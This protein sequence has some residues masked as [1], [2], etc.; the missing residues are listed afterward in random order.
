MLS[1]RSLTDKMT[2]LTKRLRRFL[3]ITAAIA[4]PALGFLS[5]CRS[6]KPA[7]GIPGSESA[8][9]DNSCADRLKRVAAS[10]DNKSWDK[11]KLPL[12]V[13]GLG[14]PVSG[15]MFLERGKSVYISLKFLGAEVAAAPVTN[16]SVVVIDKIHSR[17][18]AEPLSALTASF[19]ATVTNM[20]ALLLGQPFILGSDRIAKSDF[21]QISVENLNSP[22]GFWTMTPPETKGCSYTFTLSPDCIVTA[23]NASTRSGRKIS[24]LYSAHDTSNPLLTIPQ[25]ITIE[26]PTSRRNIGISLSYN[27][28]KCSRGENVAIPRV[29]IPAGASRIGI[30]GL[31]KL[32]ESL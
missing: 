21:R 27:A 18:F 26:M 13:G 2:N 23:L 7:S 29:K 5:S 16:D 30:E 20:Q 4:V 11:L 17:Y 8:I 15:N 10:T 28:A 25:K 32:I 24:A 19:P 14:V 9:I 22:E 31:L 6:S 12:K 1:T 3:V